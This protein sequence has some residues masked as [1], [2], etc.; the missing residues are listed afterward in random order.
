MEAVIR[1]LCVL[2]AC[3]DW[4]SMEIMDPQGG[5]LSVARM[6]ELAQLP[7]HLV[8]PREHE[9]PWR[10][11][12]QMSCVE[13][14]L[15][16]LRDSLF[17]PYTEQHRE[18]KLDGRRR[19]TGPAKR[20][21]SVGL[22]KKINLYPSLKV[23]QDYLKAKR[24]KLEDAQFRAGIGTDLAVSSALHK[25]QTAVKP[26]VPPQPSPALKGPKA[27]KASDIHRVSVPEELIDAVHEEYPDWPYTA[28]HAEAA[29]RANAPPGSSSGEPPA[30]G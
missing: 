18:E 9:E 23:R 24:Q 12:H 19:C 5:Y 2:V 29:R 6:A 3:C 26:P 14:A 1:V 11:R 27:V 15:R 4:I 16:V 7:V 25:T 21:L 28:V 17:M 8:P 10:R 13:R 22:F 20:K 30:E